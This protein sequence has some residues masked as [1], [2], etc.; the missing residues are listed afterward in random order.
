MLYLVPTNQAAQGGIVNV[1][2]GTIERR[3]S[4]APAAFVTED[5]VDVFLA[6]QSGLID[7]PRDDKL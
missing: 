2:N 6:K 5:E 4:P 3:A 1:G 7:R